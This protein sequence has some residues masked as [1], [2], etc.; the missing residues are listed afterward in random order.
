MPDRKRL[1]NRRPHLSFEFEHGIKYTAGVGAAGDGEPIMEIF[2]NAGKADSDLDIAARDAAIAASIA[3][4]YGASLDTLF[5]SMTRNPDGSA[6]G[7]L[8]HAIE[9]IIKGQV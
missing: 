9:M 4:Q 6:S 7:P 8:G 3:L 2:L 1:P 5:H